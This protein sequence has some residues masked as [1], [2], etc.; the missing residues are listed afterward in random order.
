MKRDFHTYGGRRKPG[1]WRKLETL[2]G[3]D[4]A[5][6]GVPCQ[7]QLELLEDRTVPSATPPTL[8][9]V[10]AVA[11]SQLSS[12]YAQLPMSFELNQGQTDAQVNFLSRGMGYTLFLTPVEAVLALQQDAGGSDVV[13]MDLVGGNPAAAAVGL[14][15]LP[16]HSNY[17]LGNDPSRWRT[18][19]PNYAR[20]GY[21]DVYPGTDLVYYGNQRQLEYDFVV[22]PGADPGKIG[23]HFEGV[24]GMALDTAGNL[25]LQTAGGNV[26]E[27]APVVYQDAGGVRHLVA[28]EYRLLDGN[29]VTFAVGT[30]D[31]SK[32]LIIDPVLAYSTYLGGSDFDFSHRI[33]VDSSGAAYVTGGTSSIDFPT[34]GA[35]QPGNGGGSID[36]FV[37]KLNAAGTALVYST[38][39]GGSGDDVGWGI[40]VDSG[41]NA[42]VAGIT[43]SAD[44]PTASPVQAAFGGGTSD[45]FLVKLS[46]SGSAFVYSTYLGGSGNDAAFDMALD[47]GGD[48]YVTG[49]TD[50]TNFP[51]A[52]PIQAHLKTLGVSDAFV[53]EIN[54]AGTA[55]IYS[56]YL[57]GSADDRGWSID[58]DSAGNAYVAGQTTSSDFPTVSPIQAANGGFM[59]GFVVKINARGTALDY[60]TYLGGSEDDQA[61]AIAVDNAG[62]AYVTGQTGSTD[63]PTTSL[64]LQPNSGGGF[65]AFVTKI[66]ADGSAL[67][68]STYL[69][70]SG[71]D[72]AFGIAI[73]NTG[74]A[75]V[76]GIT[77]SGDFP[78]AAPIQATYAGGSDAFVSELN[79]AGADLIF[80]SYLGGSGSD[81]GFGIAVDNA[82]N[83]YIAGSTG[84]AD[85]PTTSPVQGSFGGGVSDAFV[86]KL[87]PEV[88][89]IINV[90]GSQ[91]AFEDVDLSVSGISVSDASAATLTVTLAVDHGTLTIGTTKGLI[92]AGNGQQSVSLTGRIDRVNVA[93]ATLHYRGVLN[94]SGPDQLNITASAGDLSA[95]VDVAIMVESATEQAAALQSEVAALQ[96]AGVLTRG[97]AKFLIGE[98]NLQGTGGDVTRVEAFL[99]EV[100]ALLE[101][102]TLTKAQAIGLLDAGNTLLLSVSR[103]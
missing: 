73:D 2:V 9:P 14:D 100:N 53:T 93:L 44:F 71:V 35:I 45:A 103:R 67:D 61:N 86:V 59:D 12:A 72:H 30:Y 94:Y 4:S 34:V 60:A 19:V 37:A 81:D 16:G 15:E 66:T 56:T 68:Y 32:P 54:A 78:T 13:H 27:R 70:G 33:T 102:G 83:I 31:P 51:T 7:P 74:N 62:N 6:R 48:V 77:T 41:G 57:G 82:G 25:V 46:P 5:R 89:P 91:T 92:V 52:N 90:P 65:H 29:D 11:Q 24:I 88:A 26:V 22:A 42:Y 69:G 3:R 39:L 79:A 20:V 95:M 36:A 75:Y 40:R 98:L 85:F 8:M 80:S 87:A 23:L 18:D 47:T 17:L 38:Y 99:T 97:Q 84:S 21:H 96:V 64:A 10:S 28:G 55:L 50:S 101:A 63:F 49:D 43:G 1:F 58:V 76:T